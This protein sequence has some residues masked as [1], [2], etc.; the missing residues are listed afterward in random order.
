VA[1]LAVP[2][3]FGACNWA[4][5]GYSDA[6]TH[7][8][9][10]ETTITLS[11][12]ST[13]SMQFYGLTGDKNDS[14]PVVSNGVMYIG[15]DDHKLY[16]F[17][18]SGKTNCTTG[19]P[20]AC[21]PLWTALTGGYVFATPV[22]DSGV[23]YVGST[24]GELYAFDAAGNTNCS[25]T[26]KTC[27]PLWTASVG[28]S[29]GA[30]PIVVNGVA[31]VDGDGFISAFD[32]SGTTNCSGTPKTCA[33]LWTARMGGGLSSPAVANGVL[34][35]GSFNDYLYAFDATGTTNCSGT[36]KTCAPLWTAK[37]NKSIYLSSPSVGN[38]EVYVG[39]TDGTLYA[40]D[41]TGQT[42]CSGTPKTCSPLWTAATGATINSSPAL[43]YG[44]VYIGSGNSLSVYDATGTTNCSG[45]PK[46][47]AP[48]WTATTGGPISSPSV[49]D[50]VVFAASFDH[51]LY[52]YDAAGSVNCSGTPT[53]CTP[54]WTASTGSPYL[55]SPTVVNGM[56]YIGSGDHNVYAY[57]LSA[58]SPAN[59]PPASLP[60]SSYTTG[61][62]I[63]GPHD[64]T[65]GSDGAL[66]FTNFNDSIG[67]ITTSG[68]IT[69]YPDAGFEPLAIAPGTDGAL[70]FTNFEGDSIGRITTTGTITDYRNPAIRESTG[71][72]PGSDGAMWFVNANNSIGRITLASGG[73]AP[74]APP[75]RS[76][77]PDTGAPVFNR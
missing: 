5:F 27:A 70:W 56:V 38:G 53:T 48:L 32:S 77:A 12:V 36:P 20:A 64:I 40:F 11:N 42:N 14:S 41:A 47:C 24:D 65:V 26:P 35:V 69:N 9:N 58:G 22:V 50:G 43:A 23:V 25:G 30:S 31:Y 6:H 76:G 13:L 61:P 63:D 3:L 62:G 75:I 7:F 68:T 59:P 17:D 46:T 73:G 34:Y 66:W 2:L 55:G 1:F 37:T 28:G 33:P 8:N 45:T 49:A 72:T 74:A 60:F 15:S 4:V 44:N 16:A 10:V 51:N 19:V 21:A 71:I 52:A 29:I 57:G 39:S 67:R 18:A 54:L